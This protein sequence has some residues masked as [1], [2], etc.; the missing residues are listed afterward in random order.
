MSTIYSVPSAGPWYCDDTAVLCDGALLNGILQ[1][2]IPTVD[3]L[4]DSSN[5]NRFMEVEGH[6]MRRRG[7]FNMRGRDK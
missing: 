3:G 6:M 7:E 5:V 4:T 2:N 1:T